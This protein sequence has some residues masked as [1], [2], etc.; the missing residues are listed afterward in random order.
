MSC[1]VMEKV[2]GQLIAA[3]KIQCLGRVFNTYE[4]AGCR[5]VDAQEFFVGLNDSGVILT[6]EETEKLLAGLDTNGDGNVNYDQFLTTIRG[7]MN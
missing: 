2:K 5:R 3:Q 7:E 1:P 6:K 4:K